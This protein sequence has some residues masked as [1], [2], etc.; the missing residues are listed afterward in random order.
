[1]TE[2]TTKQAIKQKKTFLQR[3][4]DEYR[5]FREDRKIKKEMAQD[6]KDYAKEHPGIP[7]Q[8][9]NVNLSEFRWTSKSFA[10][11]VFERIVKMVRHPNVREMIVHDLNAIATGNTENERVGYIQSRLGYT[12]YREVT[13]NPYTY[14]I[15]ASLVTPADIIKRNFMNLIYRGIW[16]Y[17]NAPVEAR[18]KFN[19][20]VMPRVKKEKV[21]APNV[22]QQQ[23]VR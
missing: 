3:I 5:K 16:V 20:A 9:Q 1:M 21:V 19:K 17:K 23:C 10:L 2:S 14:P 6:S 13:G 8:Y 18:E 4:R 7:R 12:I 11:G 15:Y 22:S